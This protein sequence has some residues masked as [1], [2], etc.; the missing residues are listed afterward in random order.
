MAA[1]NAN[2]ASLT[3]IEEYRALY[4]SYLQ[5]CN[6]H[7]FEG[8]EDFYTSPLQVNDE[9]WDPKKVT[10]QFG[11]LVTAFP[12]WH[13]EVKHLTIEGD[14]LAL[15]FKVTGTH[16]GSFQGIEATGRKITTSQFT[17]YRVVEG[18]KF[19]DVWDLVDVEAVVKQIS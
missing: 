2:S 15:H 1:N 13:W 5:K 11:P 12:D 19:G 17:L 16:R 14:Y 18:N 8:M 3:K 7:D 4:D 6:A 9:P 10:A